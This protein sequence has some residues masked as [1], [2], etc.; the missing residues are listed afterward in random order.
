MKKV[1]LTLTLMLTFSEPRQRKSPARS[2]EAPGASR[3]TVRDR[4]QLTPGSTTKVIARCSSLPRLRLC[5]SS[6][7]PMTII[8]LS[9]YG[10]EAFFPYS[11]RQLGATGHNRT[12]FF[13]HVNH[14]R[15]NVFQK[16]WVMRY[17]D[18]GLFRRAEGVYAV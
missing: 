2:S 14:V 11:V 10:L 3:L 7:R 17:Y 5:G 8:L 13:E 4:S 16:F 18:E 12:A 1:I 15:P 9:I 6:S